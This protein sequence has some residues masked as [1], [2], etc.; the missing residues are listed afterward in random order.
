[1]RAVSQS[2]P[3][4][5]VGGK[6][7]KRGRRFV[8]KGG[9]TINDLYDKYVTPE[10]IAKAPFWVANKINQARNVY[11]N[12]K[13][14]KNK[15]QGFIANR[16]KSKQAPDNSYASCVSQCKSK[17]TATALATS[18]SGIRQTPNTNKVSVMSDMNKI[19]VGA[20]V[21]NPSYPSDSNAKPGRSAKKTSRPKLGS[22]K[23]GGS[24]L[25]RGP[26]A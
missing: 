13:F 11:S 26:I 22:I 20:M 2:V 21:T 23:V 16:K 3:T 12:A 1:M 9:S 5:Y 6:I 8:R 19:P 17:N 15:I 10:N 25:M 24:Q 7:K 18:A 14:V 4:P